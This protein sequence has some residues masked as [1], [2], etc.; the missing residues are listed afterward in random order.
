LRLALQ[1]LLF[2]LPGS[3]E[4]L[5]GGRVD[6]VDI[7]SGHDPVPQVT[8]QAAFELRQGLPES[9]DDEVLEWL[10]P[11]QPQCRLGHPVEV[12]VEGLDVL[13]HVLQLAGR[14]GV[15]HLPRDI[16]VN[17]LD[18]LDLPHVVEEQA[19]IVLVGQANGIAV[20]LVQDELQGPHDDLLFEERTV[21][22]GPVEV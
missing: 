9:A 22:D 20:G 12:L 6:D 21:P 2:L 13:A 3:L 18:L 5:R 14:V 11:Q 10:P 17:V 1:E 8:M 4:D 15:A 7:P 19:S 16:V